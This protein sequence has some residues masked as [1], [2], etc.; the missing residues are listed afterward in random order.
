MFSGKS[1]FIAVCKDVLFANNNL[2]CFVFLLLFSL[3]CHVPLLAFQGLGY[4]KEKELSN[5]YTYRLNSDSL[6]Q[7]YN[8]GNLSEKLAGELLD[9]LW[10][11]KYALDRKAG[12]E[13]AMK[14]PDAFSKNIT[15]TAV[16]LKIK[17]QCYRRHLF[18]LYSNPAEE[19]A[20][21][22]A[23][24]NLAIRFDKEYVIVKFLLE[25]GRAKLTMGETEWAMEYFL[26]AKK[27]L[28]ETS[29]DK[30][31][32]EVYGS[33]GDLFHKQ[34]DYPLAL[35]FSRKA[36]KFAQAYHLP[37]DEALA[38]KVMGNCYLDTYELDSALM[39]F[40]K[41]VA[42]ADASGEQ[43]FKHLVLNNIGIVYEFKREYQKAISTYET[44]RTF[45]EK[46]QDQ[47]KMG[48]VY[49]DLGQANIAMK[50]YEESLKWCRKCYD[51]RK[52]TNNLRG[53]S[54]AAQCLYVSYKRKGEFSN[55]M[56]FLEVF[57]HAQDKEFNE[58]NTKAITALNLQHEFDKEKERTGIQHQAELERAALIRK[59]LIAGLLLLG[60]LLFLGYLNY[61][62]KQKANRE[63]ALQKQ[64][65]EEANIIKDRIFAIIG[66]DLRKPAIAF[67]GITKKVNY[68]LQQ[69]DYKTL[70]VLGTEIENDAYALNK[71]TDNLLNWALL[72]KNVMPFNPELLNLRDVTEEVMDI[73]DKLAREKNLHL[74]IAME[75]NLMVRADENSLM[76][77][78][79][80]LLDNA[81][82]YTP[83]G[84]RIEIIG[85]K[86]TE[87]IKLQIKDN[88]IGMPESKMKDI[89]LLKKDKSERGTRGEKGT[90][91]GMHLV[92]ELVQLNKGSIDVV[93]NLGGGT[94]FNVLLPVM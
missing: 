9:Q 30:Y 90:G 44:C 82:K 4:D 38:W 45:F 39:H 33:I 34:A 29:K 20:A 88:G 23:A 12:I 65:L 68:L 54:H 5:F 58:K 22:E 94:V 50:N 28:E 37:K 14:V 67:R 60:L 91:L 25:N 7:I 10:S 24:K 36:L 66:H 56:Q 13:E 19:T 57:K 81:I 63:I 17:V 69:Q 49:F 2:K 18:K 6:W 40:N 93:S 86:E 41:A 61:A 51:I 92:A 27:L 62:N 1:I 64:Q 78:I 80:N 47:D 52:A 16:E 43:N 77:V 74:G 31:K 21:K 73:F 72:Q 35:E 83:E 76:T 26:E 89:F 53:F 32:A 79:R 3:M 84:G 15:D 42:I 59:G 70:N 87:G 55:A 71:L 8:K 46:E 85:I 11:E 48:N 75:P